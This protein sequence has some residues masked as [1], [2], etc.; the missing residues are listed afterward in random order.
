MTFHGTIAVNR[1][2]DITFTSTNPQ[3]LRLMLPSGAGQETLEEQKQARVLISIFYSN[4]QKLEV[5]MNNQVVPPLEWWMLANNQYNFSM[6]LP[7]V[8]DPCG[9]N[10]FAAWQNKIHVLLC[11]G[12][13]G[14]E[15][16]TV[17]AVVLSLGI[18]V[19]VEEFFDSHYLVRNL[20]SL[21]GIPSDRMRVPKIVPGSANV[22]VEVAKADLCAEVES[23]GPH[24][25]CYEGECICEDGWT[26][27]VSCAG[28]DC[29][30]SKQTCPADCATCRPSDGTC[31]SCE[32]SGELPLLLGSRCVATCPPNY[33]A[34][35]AGVCYA[36]HPSCGGACVG[37][38]PDQCAVCDSVGANAYLRN[39]ECVLSCGVGF[40]ADDQRVCHG[41]WCPSPTRVV[42]CRA[43]GVAPRVC[44]ASLEMRPNL[45][46][47][48]LPQHVRGVYG[49]KSF[50]MHILSI[51]QVRAVHVSVCHHADPRS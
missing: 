2:Y 45:A 49:P 31:T 26:S 20:A 51:Q 18:E 9:S 12:V 23:C 44:P 11:G 19:T 38:R 34:D 15:I 47:S 8:T 21:F 14:L 39:G 46:G 28:G 50:G 17:D 10:A 32:L 22:D 6:R 13:P 24:G 48:R 35:P 16:K 42:P 37:P 7:R 40:Y 27:P 41:A 25:A 3:H 30:C 29:H 4:P 5:H 1:S 43:C 36:C 33:A